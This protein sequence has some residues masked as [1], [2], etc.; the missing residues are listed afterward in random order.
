MMLPISTASL[1]G[2]WGWLPPFTEA[3]TGRP[4]LNRLPVWVPPLSSFLSVRVHLSFNPIFHYIYPGPYRHLQAGQ[5]SAGIKNIYIRL[6]VNKIRVRL[7]LYLNDPTAAFLSP[8][9]RAPF[10][11]FPNQLLF[12]RKRKGKSGGC[13]L[14]YP[15]ALND[16]PASAALL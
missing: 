10:S 16:M 1:P 15:I 4:P 8:Y 13:G 12:F 9:P 14:I 2:K 11:C 6:A 3:K 5:Y 7:P